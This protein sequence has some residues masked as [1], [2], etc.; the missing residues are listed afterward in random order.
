VVIPGLLDGISRIRERFTTLLCA[1]PQAIREFYQP[2]ALF[3]HLSQP[4]L[5]GAPPQPAI[6]RLP[7]RPEPLGHFLQGHFFFIRTRHFPGPD[8]PSCAM[9]MPLQ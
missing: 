2:N 6:D 1:P 3:A 5:E 8:R 9:P 7:V 4:P